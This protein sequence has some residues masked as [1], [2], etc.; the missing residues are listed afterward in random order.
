MARFKIK[1][2]SGNQDALD[3]FELTDL[4]DARWDLY[5]LGRPVTIFIRREKNIKRDKYN[6]ITRKNNTGV[7]ELPIKAEVTYEPSRKQL[8][9]AGIINQ[10]DVLVTMAYLDMLDIKK[11]HPDID[12]IDWTVSI[13]R[14]EYNIDEFNP[15][16][17]VG[18]S[19]KH[20][21]LSL[22]SKA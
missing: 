21:A 18:S 9:R 14:R 17:Q 12:M 16:D 3:F 6:S 7:E 1:E 13:D 19:Y 15:T 10:R 2:P 11:K 8:D 4:R 5:E 22:K 20:I